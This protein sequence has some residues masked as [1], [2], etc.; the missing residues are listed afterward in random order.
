MQMTLPARK[1]LDKRRPERTAWKQEKYLARM[2]RRGKKKTETH[3]KGP[4]SPVR[5]L[6]AKMGN[7][8]ETS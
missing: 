4:K 8:K 2:T 7:E 6:G 3:P 5:P 1:A